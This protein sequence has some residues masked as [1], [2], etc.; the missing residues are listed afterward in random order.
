MRDP[1]R[2]RSRSQDGR[3]LRVSQFTI[4]WCEVTMSEP[5]NDSGLAKEDSSDGKTLLVR[6]TFSS[7]PFG[8]P[9][10]SISEVGPQSPRA[11]HTIIGRPFITFFRV[12]RRSTR[13]GDRQ[14]R[15]PLIWNEGP[16]LY[17]KPACQ[18]ALCERHCSSTSGSI[19][20]TVPF[21]SFAFVKRSS[22]DL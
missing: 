12:F 20:I 4:H 8:I 11:V 9:S 3:F 2:A 7:D 6:Q 13:L 19:Q 14:Y 22:R 18:Y 16:L 5:G 17:I 1:K 21:D 10:P 15:V